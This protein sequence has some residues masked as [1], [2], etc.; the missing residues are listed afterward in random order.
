MPQC[1]ECENY[2]SVIKFGKSRGKQ[3]YFCT[4]EWCNKGTF[5]TTNEYKSSGAGKWYS[6]LFKIQTC[7]KYR[8]MAKDGISLRKAAKILGISHT[9]LSRWEADYEEIRSKLSGREALDLW[10]SERNEKP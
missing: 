6:A 9:S 1:P 7:N 5:T 2:D 4:T 8:N 3:R 10:E